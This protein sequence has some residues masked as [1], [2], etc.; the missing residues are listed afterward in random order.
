ML[1]FGGWLLAG[2]VVFAWNLSVR[3]PL[4]AGLDESVWIVSGIAL[5][6][7]YRILYRRARSASVPYV[8]IGL[9]V[10]LFS[11]GGAL[12]WYGSYL[13]LIRA[14]FGSIAHWPVI[15]TALSVEFSA[16]AAQPWTIS[17]RTWM[18]C[19]SLLLSWSSLYFCIN[20]IIDM[21]AQRERAVRAVKLADQARL[22]A[23]QSQ[24]HPHFLF[25]VH[26]GIATLI[27]ENDREAALS[28]IDELSE[29]VRSVVQKLDFPE[30]SVA[31]E[32][33]LVNQYLKLQ[34]RRFGARLRATVTAERDTMNARVPTLILQPLVE[35]A[36]EHGILTLKNGG[37]VIVSI[38]KFG[39][40]LVLSVDDDGV[41]S[42]TV[43]QTG[44]GLRNCRDRLEAL[45]GNE[46]H[47]STCR[48]RSGKGFV[49]VIELPYREELEEA[50]AWDCNAVAN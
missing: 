9:L 8:W 27:R 45:Y 31:E 14:L 33:A 30:I 49:V 6:F 4:V 16:L 10:L 50:Y 23:L 34:R 11:A 1:H 43:N 20:A 3:G 5:T 7:G 13:I 44:L 42:D 36:L 32:L 39:D 2:V 35:N 22:S 19:S 46:A 17:L 18:T 37:S 40:K 15:G 25:N 48:G 12:I 21:E 38:R 24:L 26:N 47:L 41:G 28:M 29:F